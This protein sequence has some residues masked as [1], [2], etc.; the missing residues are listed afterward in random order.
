MSED[1]KSTAGDRDMAIRNGLTDAI[2]SGG[3]SN[4]LGSQ[5][6]QVD[7]M[8]KNNRWYLVSNMR[9]LLSESYVEHGM[10]Q[11]VVDVPVEDA[12]RGGVT[13]KTSQLDD[14]EITLL[15]N[16]ME[17]EGDLEIVA[18]ANKWNRLFGGA[19]IIIMTDQK[20]DQEL[21]IEKITKDSRVEFRA[22]DM[23][24]L[25]YSKQNTDDYSLAI[26][27]KHFE[28]DHFDYYGVRLSTSRVLKLK[29]LKAPSFIRPRLRGWGVS[30]ME[31]MVR[32]INQY[33]KATD[34]SFEVLDEFKVDVFK[35]KGLSST[36][37][38]QGG[39]AKIQQR[40]QLAN[41]QKNYQ[42]A[43][44]MDGEDDYMQK[45]LSFAGL[46]EAMDGIRKQLAS[47]LR[48]PLT[49]IFGISSAGFNS[50]EDDIENYNAMI[51]STIRTGSKFEIMKI[52]EIR[53]QQLFGFIPD[54]LAIDY[55]PLRVLS[56]EQE[57]NVKN[58]KFNRVLQARQAG[59]IS[60]STFKEACNREDLLPIKLEIDDE[61]F[62]TPMNGK[63]GDPPDVAT[64]KPAASTLETPKAK[65]S[66]DEVRKIAVMGL[67]SDG[68]TL[69]GRRR[70]NNLWVSPSGH[71]DPGETPLEAA[72][73]ECSEEA[74]IDNLKEIAKKV[75]TFKSSKI[76][77][78]AFVAELDSRMMAKTTLDPDSEVS[79]WRWVPI[80]KDTPELMRE[81][82]HS[83]IDA[84]VEHLLGGK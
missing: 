10:V 72:C 18:E 16:K 53:C 43:I 37:L 74:G 83:K 51:E 52:I 69:R 78:H 63:D 79:V 33:L 57:E 80:A 20:P 19:G 81:N 70:D 34:L 31:T 68:Y 71:F 9:Q 59:E 29:G 12:F 60:S 75:S 8:F 15:E 6:S 40:I 67:V 3:G 56:S 32:S 28:T 64:P 25:Y 41:Q 27:E 42:H 38:S 50:G 36:L 22:V 65:N 62:P 4:G 17:R 76:E 21:D 55:V 47:D 84:V 82:S 7:T 73:R 58:N 39:T 2:F 30:V 24:E 54:D 5:L 14:D 77:V 13:I 23:W 26:D 45:Q 46:A 49:K 11:T 48:M 44:T 35:I 61:I 66:N 1:K